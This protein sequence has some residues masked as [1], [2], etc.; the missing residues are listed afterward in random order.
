MVDWHSSMQQL[1]EYY[2]VDPGTWR[3][4]QRLDIVES[5]KITR[6]SESETLGSATFDVIGSVG[7]CYIRAYLVTIQNGVKERHALGTFL[8]QTPSSSFDGKIRTVSMDAYTPLLELKE[9]PPPLGYSILKNDDVDILGRAYSIIK[10][11]V[12]VPVIKPS[13][14]KTLGSNFVAN[15]DDTWLT[16]TKDLLAL[17]EH[18]FDLDELGRISFAPR[19]DVE[20]MQAIWTFTDDNSSILHA[21]IR[22]EHDIY[23]IP[24]VVQVI[25][26]DGA[27]YLETE[28][29]NDD[30][31]SPTSTV[32]RGRR[33]VHRVVNPSLNGVPADEDELE[34]YA[35]NLL[36]DLSSVE[37]TLSYTH[38]YCPVRLGDCVRLNYKKAGIMDV[39]AKVVSQSIKCEPGCPVSEKAVFTSKLWR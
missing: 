16:F 13:S 29:A 30:P 2:V 26:S 34:K 10:D 23:N 35:E 25:Y 18:T 28:I 36:K 3:D 37:Y 21:S 4:S 39:K 22:M 24:N 38:G 20:S 12:R 6:D 14:R 5:C 7:E 33:I 9:S 8:A 17:A 1:F 11:A 15:V 27:E 32:R 31:N 19:Q